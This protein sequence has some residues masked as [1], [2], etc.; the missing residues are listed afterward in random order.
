[1]DLDWLVRDVVGKAV[2][3][4]Q[5]PSTPDLRAAAERLLADPKTPALAVFLAAN[6]LLGPEFVHFE[7]ETLWLELDPPPMNRDKLLASIALAI[8]P[9]F[10]WDYRVFANTVLALNNRAAQPDDVP[11]CEAQEIAW[12]VYEAE[13]LFA[14]TD[15]TGARPFFDDG[16]VVYTAT[17][18][19]DEGFIHC[20]DSLSFCEEY[21]KKLLCHDDECDYSLHDQVKASW[22]TFPKDGLENHKFDE[23]ALGVQLARQAEVHLY[24]VNRANDLITCLSKV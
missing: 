2:A 17:T 23:T 10:Y 12:A 11:R 13:I 18:L 8:R 6:R 24:L 21:F 14:L 3:A 15:N 4:Y 20:P 9:S 1:M 5:R 22:R 7:P 19:F 16:P